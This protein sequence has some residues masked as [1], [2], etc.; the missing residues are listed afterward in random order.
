[1]S[2]AKERSRRSVPAG[3]AGWGLLSC[4]GSGPWFVVRLVIAEVDVVRPDGVDFAYTFDFLH[5]YA[6]DAEAQ[7][8]HAHRAAVTRPHH[9]ELDD[10]VVAHVHDVHVAGVGMDIGTN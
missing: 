8:E 6:F 10:A 1:M 9:L 4:R 3:G 2:L 7:G 5:Q